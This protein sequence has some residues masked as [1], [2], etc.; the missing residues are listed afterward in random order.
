MMTVKPTMTRT[1]LQE[2][3]N[4]SRATSCC[5]VVISS[6]HRAHGRSLGRNRLTN[7]ILGFRKKY[8]PNARIAAAILLLAYVPKRNTE[9]N[10]GDATPCPTTDPFQSSWTF[11]TTHTTSRRSAVRSNGHLRLGSKPPSGDPCCARARG[12]AVEDLKADRCWRDWIA[13]RFCYRP[14]EGVSAHCLRNA[15]VGGNR[16][17]SFRA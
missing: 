15:R 3:I 13:G 9:H 4:R 5:R 16:V 2:S 14:S 17:P 10:R 8:S 12:R 1:S 11:R 6:L 7:R